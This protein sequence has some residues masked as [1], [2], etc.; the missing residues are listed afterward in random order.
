MP[1][2]KVL[3]VGPKE[4]GKT[5]IANF[6]AE[7][8]DRL[9]NQERYQPTIGVRIL[10]CEKN[11]GR[12]QVSVEF[13]D[14]SG[15]QIYEACW[16]AILKDAHATLLV[17]NPESHVHESEVT[18]WYEWFVQNAGLDPSQCLVFAHSPNKTGGR[19]KVNLPPSLK[20]VQT[21]YEAATVLKSEFDA[22]LLTVQDAVQRQQRSRK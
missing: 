22:F 5:A 1:S 7:G 14:C 21:N 3:V 9:G 6:L 12:G 18:L 16:P 20:T 2:L 10:E 11:L 15:D 13:W 17:Y 19:G 8:T 4:G